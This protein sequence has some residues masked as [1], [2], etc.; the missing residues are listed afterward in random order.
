MY[1]SRSSLRKSSRRNRLSHRRRSNRSHKR[2]HQR[3]GRV[4]L[5]SEYFGNDSGRYFAPG[6]PELM[7]SG[8][9]Y[10][11]IYATS[12]GTILDGNRMGPDLAPFPNARDQTGGARR[13]RR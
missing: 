3:G 9:A 11:P 8:G 12:H 2:R 1:K 13:R 4:V 10:G 7:P 6:S 5:P